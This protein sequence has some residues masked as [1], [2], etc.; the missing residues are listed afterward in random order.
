MAY[1]IAP[2]GEWYGEA[3]YESMG[4]E[5]TYMSP[6]QY[7]ASVRP[8]VMDEISRDNID[9]LV[10]HIKSGRKLDPLKIYSN[11]KEDGR[12]RA[13]AAKE[14]GISKVP[15]IVFG[16]LEE[17]RLPLRSGM[18]DRAKGSYG[19]F[20]IT[21]H[22]L[23][24]LRLTTH[25]E[26][27]IEQIKSRPFPYRKEDL[28]NS[29]LDG[30]F[31]MPFLYVEF[32]SGQIRG[33]EGRHR[34]AMILARG[35]NVFP[36]VIYPYADMGYE[37][38]AVYWDDEGNRREYHSDAFSTE[39]LAERAVRMVLRDIPP[40]DILRI[41]VNYIGNKKMKGSPRSVGWERDKWQIGDFPK[42]L[43]GQFAPIQVTDYRVGLVK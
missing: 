39:E 42:Q 5:M 25:N 29:E 36:V 11:G 7:I 17:A 26:A 10:Q 22:P 14:L 32:P 16:K 19:A 28:Y 3:N 33:H 23:D 9:D 43:I 20:V 6:D 21:M 18:I 8:L 31:E 4:G 38:N 35:G 30:K 2:R 24:F 13:Y 1:P 40:D 41:S 27:E 37:A 34:A 15:V 12:H